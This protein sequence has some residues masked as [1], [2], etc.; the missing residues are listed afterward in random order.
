VSLADRASKD[1]TMGGVADAATA[2]TEVE[3]LYNRQV[4]RLTALRNGLSQP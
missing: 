3:G 2:Q 4:E 1:A